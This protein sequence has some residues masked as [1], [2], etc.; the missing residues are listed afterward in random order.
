[1]IATGSGGAPP[2]RRSHATQTSVLTS[3]KEIAQYVGKGIRTAQ[4]WELELGFPVRRAKAG[5]KSIVLAVPGEIDAWLQS[6]HLGEQPGSTLL[7][8]VK[9]LRSENR[10]LRR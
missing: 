9:G 2:P 8:T 7:R 3:W 6:Q 1:M 10:K 5:R 4:R